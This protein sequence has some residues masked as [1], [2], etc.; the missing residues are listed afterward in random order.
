M[1]APYRERPRFLLC[2]RCGEMLDHAFEGVSSCLRC[3][4]LWIAPATLDSAFGDPLWPPGQTLWW[5]NS[6]ECPDCAFDGVQTAM[7]ARRSSD[8]IVDHCPSHGIWLDRGELGRLMSVP[9]DDLAAL[10][11][12]LAAIAPDLDELVARREKWRIDVEMR[13]K[14]ALDYRQ[15]V[16]EERRR[17]AVVAEA[18]R[19]RFETDQRGRSQAATAPTQVLPARRTGWSEPPPAKTTREV[20]VRAAKRRQS[21]GTQRTP[22]PVTEEAARQ[23]AHRRQELVGQRAQASADVGVLQGRLFALDEHLRRLDA[24]LADTRQHAAAVRDELNSARMRL[25]V[26]DEQLGDGPDAPESPGESGH[27]D[28][29]DEPDPADPPDPQDPADQRDASSAGSEEPA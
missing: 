11:A 3:E 19:Q 21:L 29:L 4:G 5:R 13:R 28:A 6:I 14:A 2:P 20:A 17:R 27:S 22:V 1:G 16:E 9:D 10:R 23:A 8:V 25:R 12:R 7:A 18:E 24:Q 15:A 26:L